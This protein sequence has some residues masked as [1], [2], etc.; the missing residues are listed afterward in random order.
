MAFVTGSVNNFDDLLTAIRNACTANGWT[1]SG[2]V[3]WKGGAYV[4]A[5]VN[6]NSIEFLGG[7]GKD[8]SHVLTD[9]MG[10]KVRL[11]SI[12]NMAVW[13]FPVTYEVHIFT[14]PDEVY[15]VVN[16]DTTKFQHV[17]WGVSNIP[18]VGG[19]GLWITATCGSGT[20]LSGYGVHATSPGASGA[21]AAGGN[22]CGFPAFCMESTDS[23]RRNTWINAD[24]DGAGWKSMPYGWTTLYPLLRMQP[25]VWN[26]ETVLLPL[27]V[28]RARSSG[29]KVSMVANPPN[30]RLCRI[31]N[32]DAFDIITLGPDQWRLYPWRQKNTVHPNGLANADHSGTLGFAVRYTGP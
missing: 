21:Q 2:T 26:S 5:V 7:T 17:F 25:N 30:L 29:S 16:H 8:G 10:G 24:V 32:H 11:L 6:G 31:D 18:D 20:G 15:V 9:A 13:T 28:V 3:L 12:A 14:A 22:A 27:P 23:V 1:L 4:N 19:T